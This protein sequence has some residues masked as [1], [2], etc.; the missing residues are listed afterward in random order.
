MSEEDRDLSA[1][2]R[3]ALRAL[4]DGP[5][6]PPALEAATV[7]LL[8]KAGLIGSRRP[9][10]RM[11]LAAAAAALVLFG[12]GL[13]VGA[14]RAAP[15]AAVS[16]APRFVLLLYDAPDEKALTAALME[17]RVAEY[18]N[19][20]RGVRASGREI[21]GEKLEPEARPLGPP[22]GAGTGWPLG[23]YFVISARDLDAAVAVALTC[24]HVKHGG[25][26]E[27]RALAHT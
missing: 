13:A 18:R 11:H 7:R 5:E 22:E 9:E 1:E 12:L 21:S 26:I 20:A 23:G 10:W 14:R 8:A 19:W 24:P 27:V 15:G 25:R 16:G 2:E 17:A 3:R 4:A 6:P